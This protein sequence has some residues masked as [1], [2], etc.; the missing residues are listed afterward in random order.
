MNPNLVKGKIVLCEN[1]PNIGGSYDAVL[2]AGGAGVI[3]AGGGDS[4]DTNLL[5][6]GRAALE[7]GTYAIPLLRVTSRG[8]ET[9][10]EYLRSTRRPLAKILPTRT[11]LGV[12]PAPVVADFS[13]RGPL[14]YAAG[15]AQWLK[16]DIAAP[17][18][19]ILAAGVGGNEFAFM[20]GTSMACP[21]VSGVAALLKSV[22]PSWSPAAIRSALMTTAT[23]LN[24]LNETI[25]AQETGAAASPLDFGA[26]FI[27]PEKAMRPGLV[28]DM[29][30]HD[31]LTFMCT[32]GYPNNETRQID[33]DAPPC[34]TGRG[35]PPRVED[36]NFPSFFAV[37]GD[38]SLNSSAVTFRRILTNVET[39]CAT[40]TYVAHVVSPQGY[41]IIVEPTTLVFTK[42]M[43]KREFTLTVVPVYNHVVD[44]QFA[45]LR[46][47][48]GKHVVQSPIVIDSNVVA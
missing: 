48:D 37:F 23:M 9:L 40:A 8:R 44:R 33:R 22:H 35:L 15:H 28:Y 5:D 10:M 27:Q 1:N 21:H 7:R 16:P 41:S 39:G 38:V 6:S 17:G 43:E 24:N 11:V 30:V 42:F 3:I 20:S 12:A 32:L 34:P 31:Y 4:G 13:S 47:S 19:E 29:G 14:R 26:G 45:T 25:T 18:V 46:W 2:A 36:A